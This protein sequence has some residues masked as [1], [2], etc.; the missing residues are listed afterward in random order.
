MLRLRP[1]GLALRLRAEAVRRGLIPAQ[2]LDEDPVLALCRLVRAIPY[3]PPSVRRP[4]AVLEAWQG[5]SAGKHALLLTA[6]RE[7]GIEARAFLRTHRID[8]AQARAFGPTVEDRLPQGGLVD[9]HTW[10]AV[11]WRGRLRAVD[12]TFPHPPPQLVQSPDT[13]A[14]HIFQPTRQAKNS[15]AVFCVKKKKKK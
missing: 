8:T 4:E 15:H 2:G 10:L 6:L 1:E 13:A 3:G 7:I 9:V 14:I 12:V 11:A 5:T